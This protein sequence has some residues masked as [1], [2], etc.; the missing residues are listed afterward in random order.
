[1]APCQMD[2]SLTASVVHLGIVK[3]QMK[4]LPFFFFGTPGSGTAVDL[5]LHTTVSSNFRDK[6]LSTYFATKTLVNR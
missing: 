4:L 2:I 5:M 3:A 6:N 1:M